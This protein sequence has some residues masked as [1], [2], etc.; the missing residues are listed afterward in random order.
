LVAPGYLIGNAPRFFFPVN[1]QLNLKKMTKKQNSSQSDKS[2][3]RRELTQTIVNEMK[4]QGFLDGFTDEET[5]ETLLE[6]QFSD[7]TL[8]CQVEEDKGN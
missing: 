1:K 2:Q 7:A 5:G 6:I 4:T 8:I 3:D